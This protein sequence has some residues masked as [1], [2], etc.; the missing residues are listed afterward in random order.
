[1]SDSQCS[2]YGLLITIHKAPGWKEKRG[3]KVGK[4]E[5]GKKLPTEAD[6]QSQP[7]PKIAA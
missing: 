5:R 4:R 2:Q 7:A 3:K 6:Q 1:M